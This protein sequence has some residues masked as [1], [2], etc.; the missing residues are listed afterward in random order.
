VIVQLSRAE[1]NRILSLNS[2][3]LLSPTTEGKVDHHA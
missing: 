1:Q 2:E 3:S